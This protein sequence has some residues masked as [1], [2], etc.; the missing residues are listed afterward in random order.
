METTELLIPKELEE[1][2]PDEAKTLIKS[3]GYHL[4]K[5]IV[6]LKVT[7]EEAYTKAVELGS[8]NKKVLNGIESFRKALTKP[9]NDHIKLING[10]FKNISERFEDNDSSLR[11]QIEKYQDGRKKPESIQHTITDSGTAT[12]QKRW[13][14]EITDASLLP[15]EFLIPDDVKIRRSIAEGA[16]E[17]AGVRIYQRNVTAFRAA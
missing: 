3:E 2:L 9:L 14:F 4:T 10:M 15:K 12:I 7:N 16:R 1:Q 6:G 13:D 11:K 8:A 5:E 17:I